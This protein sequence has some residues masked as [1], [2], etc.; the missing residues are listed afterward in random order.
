M[1]HKCISKKLHYVYEHIPKLKKILNPKVL[2]PRPLAGD[3]Q[4]VL[5]KV[6]GAILFRLSD[7]RSKPQEPPE[8]QGWRAKEEPGH[9]R[10]SEVWVSVGVIF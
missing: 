8:P 3:T 6:G 10:S 5:S 9:R 7:S 2:V 1:E 4:P